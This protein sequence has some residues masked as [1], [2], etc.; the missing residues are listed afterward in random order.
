MTTA[1]VTIHHPQQVSHPLPGNLYQSFQHH[2]P[3]NLSV[4]DP[5]QRQFARSPVCFREGRRA[6]DGL[7]AQ[8]PFQQRLYDKMKAAAAIE[9]HD[10]H[11][12]C[13]ALQVPEGIFRAMYASTQFL[14]N[15]LRYRLIQASPLTGRPPTLDTYFLVV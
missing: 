5:M 12:E 15:L 2:N 1:S 4:A 7:M 11:E 3:A 10:V 14:K 6:S 13:R 9:L 8:G